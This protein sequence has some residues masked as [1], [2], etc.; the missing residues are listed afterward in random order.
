MS[1]APIWL[2][3]SLLLIIVCVNAHTII[4]KRLI[5]KIISAT[6]QMPIPT[7][8]SVGRSI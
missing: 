1:V 5:L 3:I 8:R 4:N 2:Y 6:E 7:F